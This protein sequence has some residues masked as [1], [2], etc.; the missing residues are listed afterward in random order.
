[1]ASG[2]TQVIDFVPRIFGD[3]LASDTV[4]LASK[5]T[6]SIAKPMNAA[7]NAAGLSVLAGVAV[8]LTAGSAA[9]IEFEDAFAMVKK[10]MADVKDPEVFDKIADDLQN[11]ATQIPITSTELAGVASVA[12]QLGVAADDIAVFTEVTAK[13]GVATNMTSTQAATGLAR[14]LNVTGN[15]TD[16]VGKFGSVLVQLGNNVAATESEI[17][18]LAQ[19]FG[20]TGNVAGL[21]AEDILA[22]SAATREAGVQAA[23]GATALGK[24]FMN[25]S[26][27]V[28]ESDTEKLRTLS[29]LIGGDFATAFE[30]DGALAVQQFL[31]GLSEL[32]ASGESVTPVLQTL[33][34][35]NVR[36]SRAVLSLANNNKGLA[37]A[38]KLARV[39]AATSNALNAEVATRMDTVSSKVQL[40]KSSFN[41]LLIPLGEVFLPIFK[42]ILDVA[43]NVVNGFLGL[44][45][46]FGQLSASVKGLLGVLAGSTGLST[47]FQFLN[48]GLTAFNASGGT[49][50]GI[51]TR[52]FAVFQKVAPIIKKALMPITAIILALN[53]LGKREREIREFETG[54]KNMGTTLE[55]LDADGESFAENFTEEIFEGLVEGLPKSMKEGVQKGVEAGTLTEQG[56]E[57]SQQIAD[58]LNRGLVDDLRNLADVGDLVFANFDSKQIVEDLKAEGLTEESELLK[59]VQEINVQKAKGTREASET[60]EELQDQLKVHLQIIEAEKEK[61]SFEEILTNTLLEVLTIQ[62]RNERRTKNLMSTDAGRLKLAKELASEHK[63]VNDLLVKYG[64]IAE[65]SFEK[66]PIQILV[67]QAEELEKAV[68]NIFLGPELDFARKF[69]LM[70]LTEA[71]EEEAELIQEELDLLQEQADLQDDLLDL[72]DAQIET[73]EELA[74]QQEL[75]NEALEIE[76]RLRN[77]LAL[78][79]NDQ[80]RREKLRK[81][82]RR[83]EL[84][85]A[86]GSLEFADLELEAIDENIKKIEDRAVTQQDADDLRAKSLKISEK[87]Q[88]RR[89]EEIEDIEKRRIEIG[90][91]LK[92]LP[93]EQLEAQEAILGA[94]K[95]IL[96]TNIDTIKA[97]Q[98]LG[99]VTA[100][101]AQKMAQA[102]GL[103]ASALSALMGGIAAAQVSIPNIGAQYGVNIGASLTS[104]SQQ[105]ANQMNVTRALN[106]VAGYNTSV[107]QTSS[108]NMN[109]QTSGPTFSP[110]IIQNGFT[111]GDEMMMKKAAKALEKELNKTKFDRSGIQ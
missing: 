65:T 17:L 49:T 45:R 27:A 10:T 97:M 62:E 75:I 100:I 98:Q 11:L 83:V 106:P 108:N 57:A 71:R 107:G 30:Q 9:A 87:A 1:M 25:V 84:A 14:F 16:T 5:V 56:L 74:E 52:M 76:E 40:L 32:A 51:V 66:S 24:L 48:K 3:K 59:L 103:P 38:I 35:N 46:V 41:A 111:A 104:Q 43:I 8:A 82:R 85:A 37:D 88:L 31:A 55:E 73:A 77:G 80:L 81:D 101:Q 19:N 22:F 13:L 60:V 18:L 44:Q 92:E 42:A 63:V 102:L 94:Q 2:I 99:T 53:E 67:E 34:L 78:S 68:E 93:R 6:S 72:Q 70:D 4:A 64:H 91:R 50:N 36:T 15:T 33:G 29:N 95:D 58:G 69:A 39:E 79:A 110:T 89:Q 28:K 54:I 12:G 105:Y 86:Q 23:A 20:A 96:Q 7:V 26:N 90:E 21:S 109:T 47:I 61:L